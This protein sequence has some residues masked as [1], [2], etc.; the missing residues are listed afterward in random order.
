MKAIEHS[1][2]NFT[3]GTFPGIVLTSNDRNSRDFYVRKFYL[4]YIFN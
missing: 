4:A 1:E 2:Q 3:K